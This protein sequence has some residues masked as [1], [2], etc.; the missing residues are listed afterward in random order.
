MSVGKKTLGQ[1]VQLYE[2]FD[3]VR[4]VLVARVSGEVRMRLLRELLMFV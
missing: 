1:H 3:V 2:E 4:R